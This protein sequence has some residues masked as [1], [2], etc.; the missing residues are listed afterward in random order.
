MRL[1]LNNVR[2]PCSYENLKRV[3]GVIHLSFQ[4]ASGKVSEGQHDVVRVHEENQ[5]IYT[6]I[7]MLQKLFVP[8]LLK[9]EIS[10]HK[11]I[12]SWIGCPVQAHTKIAARPR[13]LQ[14][15]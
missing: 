14:R 8:I 2:G 1:L 7:H 15:I 4:D 13:G 3:N 6:S 5:C 10:N 11:K 12:Y 9:C